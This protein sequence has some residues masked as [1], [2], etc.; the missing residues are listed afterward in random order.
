MTEPTR[1]TLGFSPCPN[2]TYIFNGLVHG[3]VDLRGAAF[4]EPVLEDVETLNAW[5]LAGRLDVSKIDGGSLA[6]AMRVLGRMNFDQGFQLAS[7]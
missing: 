6:A 1:L 5:A 4:A 3:R 2:D 7:L